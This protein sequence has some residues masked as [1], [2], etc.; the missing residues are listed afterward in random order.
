MLIDADC[1]DGVEE[2]LQGTHCLDHHHHHFHVDLREKVK[3]PDGRNYSK[4]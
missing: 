3:E 4:P 1:S 2:K